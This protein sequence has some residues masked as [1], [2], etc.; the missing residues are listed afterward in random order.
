MGDPLV[1][2]SPA[3]SSGGS[4]GTSEPSPRAYPVR[5][6]LSTRT[7]PRLRKK[8]FIPTKWDG[9]VEVS[10]SAQ[11]SLHFI[12]VQRPAPVFH[13]ITKWDTSQSPFI[14]SS[15]SKTACYLASLRAALV[16]IPAR[17][18]APWYCGP[19]GVEVQV[20]KLPASLLSPPL[21]SLQESK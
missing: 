12:P 11:L 19:D 5:E 15:D 4:S 6:R 3:P 10:Y 13:P 21:T 2:A 16:R 20:E 17:R 1:S 18:G 8:H 7:K 9:P 14:L